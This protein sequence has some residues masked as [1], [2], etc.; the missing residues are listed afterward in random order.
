MIC[1]QSNLKITPFCTSKVVPNPFDK[2]AKV[3]V[4]AIGKTRFV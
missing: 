2:P 4:A 3:P 1:F